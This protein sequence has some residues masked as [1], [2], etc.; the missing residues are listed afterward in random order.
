MSAGAREGKRGRQCEKDGADFH[1]GVY[2]AKPWIEIQDL[3]S[4]N[5]SGVMSLGG[6]SRIEN[7]GWK[8]NSGCR[9]SATKTMVS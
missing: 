8:I 6:G 2:S 4:I 5:E 1:D 7:V 3:V 9:C